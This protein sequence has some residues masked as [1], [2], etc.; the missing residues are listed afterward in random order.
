[1]FFKKKN[2]QEKKSN[3]IY[4]GLGIDMNNKECNIF[5][6]D[7]EIM[8]EE[9][10]TDILASVLFQLTNGFLNKTIL[11]AMD[12]ALQEAKENDVD[13]YAELELFYKKSIDTWGNIQKRSDEI[14]S[15]IKD[16]LSTK[17]S[18]M[19]PSKVFNI[20]RKSNVE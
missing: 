19:D 11:E 9:E 12:N 4:F 8:T 1:M 16:Q 3:K 14:E 7:R 18:K 17:K 6:D 13:N 2:K 10:N 5:F 20:R 15:S